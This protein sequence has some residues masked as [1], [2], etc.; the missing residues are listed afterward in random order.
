MSEND[1][2]N[3]K[4]RKD[5]TWSG[6]V[7]NPGK[8]F[9]LNLAAMAVRNVNKIRDKNGEIYAR[10]ALSRCGLALDRNGRWT[11][12]MLNKKLQERL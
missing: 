6:K 4:V 11:V 9:F 8:T 10:K 5:G 12:E 3:D 7:K 1:E 2:W